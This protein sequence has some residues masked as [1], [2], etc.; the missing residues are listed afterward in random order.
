MG[1]STMTIK[2]RGDSEL[3][4]HTQAYDLFQKYFI[5]YDWN[6]VILEA[7]PKQK[8]GEYGVKTFAEL[9]KLD[10]EINRNRVIE[11]EFNDLEAEIKSAQSEW[12]CNLF[13]VNV[14]SSSVI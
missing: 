11:Q 3:H 9:E 12:L 10:G 1:H 13:C 6:Y 4:A 5:R 2:V 8:L 14:F 7:I